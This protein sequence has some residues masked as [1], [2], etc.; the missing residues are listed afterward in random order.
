[1][2]EVWAAYDTRLDRR[3]ALKQLRPDLLPSGTSGRSAIARFK[4]EA[5]LTARLEHPGV[6]AIFD[7]GDHDGLLYL[8]M[9]LID[10]IDLAAALD[11]WDALPVDWAVAVGAQ[12]ATVL[13]AAHAVSLVHRDLKPR[14]VML[15]RGG[16]VRVLDFG[17][18][19]L[20]DPELTRV[21]V[22]G[23]TVGSPAYMSPEQITSGTV[24]PRSDLYAFGCVLYEL[25]AGEEPF[26]AAS[27]AAQMYAHLERAPRFLRDLRP[28]VPDGVAQLVGELLAKDPEARPPGAVEVQERLQP[29]LP[30]AGAPADR[31][32]PLD[33]TYPYRCPLAPPPAPPVMARP[34]ARISQPLA[35]VRRQAL[36]LAEDGR[37]TQAAELLSRRLRGAAELPAELL[38]ARLQLAHALLLGGEYRRALPEFEA[39][40]STLIKR[41]G[42]D[43]I[44]VLRCRVQIATCRAELGELTAAIA[45]LNDVLERWDRLDDSGVE[46]LDLRRQVALL[47]PHPATSTRPRQRC[48]S[49]GGTRNSCWV[50]RTRGA[51]ARRSAHAHTDA[52]GKDLRA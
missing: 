19:A 30:A 22:V 35:D 46:V 32:D 12:I 10:G 48:G 51:R 27:T 11:A 42:P 8:V 24:S 25:I 13:P 43:G 45:E 41:D 15:S 23:E 39:V 17:V 52:A 2:G 16:V 29:F 21:T 7:V 49:C 50:L 33:P 4:R 44:E 6:P 38:N 5:R 28:D 40:A 14:N 34:T 37:L 1:M 36:D 18:A 26:P 9:Q 3:V 20:L 31:N 47:L